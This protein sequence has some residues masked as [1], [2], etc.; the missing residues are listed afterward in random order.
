[1]EIVRCPC[2]GHGN[3]IRGSRRTRL[4]LSDETVF[5]RANGGVV[6]TSYVYDPEA[7]NHDAEY[8]YGAGTLT[9]V[10][11]TNEEIEHAYAELQTKGGL[12]R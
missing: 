8:G 7:R 1:M 2:D 12:T 4:G 5:E 11:L 10:F 3:P 6:L 9:R